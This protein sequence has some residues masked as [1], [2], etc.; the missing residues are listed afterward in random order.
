MGRQ[1]SLRDT[2]LAVVLTLVGGVFTALG[3]LATTN[4]AAALLTAGPTVERVRAALPSL[5]AV[6]AALSLRSALSTAAGWAQA[7]LEPQV[8]A[9]AE[10]EFVEL[11]T[12]VEVAAFDDPGSRTRCSGPVSAAP[13]RPGRW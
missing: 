10:V 7:R 6:A 4:V 9:L 8:V 11:T 1:A 5:I 2:V 13:A 12:S 3:V